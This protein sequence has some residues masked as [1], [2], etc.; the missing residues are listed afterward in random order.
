MK[1]AYAVVFEYEPG[2]LSAYVPDLP[3]CVGV[4]DTLEEIRGLMKEA[5]TFHIDIMRE[6]GET[7][8]E[9]RTS[10]QEALG[11]H[12]EKLPEHDEEMGEDLPKR[13]ATVELVKVDPSP[14]AIA[15]DYGP[16]E[17]HDIM[18]SPK[19]R[20]VILGRTASG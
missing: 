11:L 1:R 19:R 18:P 8:P 20:G 2:N 4:G 14:G 15:R 6:Y 9:P 17:V 7:V 16:L 5:I 13:A 12:N 10:I 3:G